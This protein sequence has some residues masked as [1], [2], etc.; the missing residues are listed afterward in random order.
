[1]L[2]VYRLG[3]SLS[4]K[5]TTN[6][7]ATT[8][9]ESEEPDWLRAFVER[10]STPAALRAALSQLTSDEVQHV[11]ESAV[12]W[13]TVIEDQRSDEMAFYAR[14]SSFVSS[15]IDTHFVTILRNP[16]LS[17]LLRQIQGL[18]TKQADL[19]QAYLKASAGLMMV[20]REAERAYKMANNPTERKMMRKAKK[21]MIED[22]VLETF[23]V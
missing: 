10:P 22:Y 17:E 7:T 18:V 1:M 13:F 14:L 16:R 2:Q 5:P 9:T 23:E 3:R 19:E 21:E 4:N 11:F 6:G 15:V 12:A 20:Q 8:E